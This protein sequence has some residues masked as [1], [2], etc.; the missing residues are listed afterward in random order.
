MAGLAATDRRVWLGVA[1]G[2]Q[3]GLDLSLLGAGNETDQLARHKGSSRHILPGRLA[4][5]CM[6]GKCDRIRS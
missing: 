2:G 4:K 3:S 5:E 1:A 6:L